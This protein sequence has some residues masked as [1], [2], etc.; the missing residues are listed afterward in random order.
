MSRERERDLLGRVDEELQQ[1]LDVAP[2]PE[3]LPRVRERVANEAS[4]SR[5]WTQPWLIPVAAGL[6]AVIATMLLLRQPATTGSPAI[7]ARSEASPAVAES[8]RPIP[9]ARVSVPE[10]PTRPLVR[11]PRPERAKTEPEVLV[12]PGEEELLRSFVA[13]IQTGRVD[14]TAL[15]AG[16]AK[17]PDLAIA[18]LEEIPSL[19]VKPLTSGTNSEGVDQ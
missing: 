15:A 6:V 12:P 19:E 18:P 16:E 3:F 8:P 11:Q 14:A 4:A 7:Q 1:T 5:A 13:G 9:E 2:G 17:P 10:P